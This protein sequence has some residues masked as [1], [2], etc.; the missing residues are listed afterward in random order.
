[1]LVAT[2]NEMFVSNPGLLCGGADLERGSEARR[3]EESPDHFPVTRAL[4]Q[5]AAQRSTA[6]RPYRLL[7]IRCAVICEARL[8]ALDEETLL[9]GAIVH[10]A[11]RL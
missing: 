7:P 8:H 6:A 11:R 1:M 10:A 5:V 9:G 3:R 4:S 2:R